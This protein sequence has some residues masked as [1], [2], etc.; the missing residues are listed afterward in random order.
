M[1]TRKSAK[2]D[3]DSFNKLQKKREKARA[4]GET[5][6]SVD[7]GYRT[8]KATPRKTNIDAAKLQAGWDA[9]MEAR[10]SPEFR[11]AGKSMR[12]VEDAKDRASVERDRAREASHYA[13][14]IRDHTN[15]SARSKQDQNV[16][17]AFQRAQLAT[18]KRAALDAYFTARMKRDYEKKQKST[19]ED[20][21]ARAQGDA[22]F[23]DIVRR[24]RFAGESYGTE[25]ERAAAYING[26]ER[27]GL[28]AYQRARYYALTEDEKN[29]VRYF[30][31]KHDWDTVQRYLDAKEQ[32]L[33]ARVMGVYDKKTQEFA[34]KHPFLGAAGHAVNVFTAPA[35]YFANA[36]QMIQNRATG[37]YVP[38]DKNSAAFSG[39]HTRAALGEGIGNTAERS[40][41]EYAY[42]NLKAAAEKAG[43]TEEQMRAAAAKGG[44]I[45]REAANIG[46]SML[47]NAITLPLGEASLAA[48]ALASAGDTTYDAL[49]RGATPGQAFAAGTA[50]GA[51]EAATEKLPLENILKLGKGGTAGFAKNVAKQFGM[52]ALEE[53]ISNVAG[54]IADQVIMGELSNY[55]QLVQQFMQQGASREEAERRANYQLYLI[56][57]LKSALAGG[58]SGGLMA[59]SA[60]V[61]GAA[62]Q[63]M[64]RRAASNAVNDAYRAMAQDGM[65]SDRARQAAN[66]AAAAQQSVLTPQMTVEQF[67][68]ARYETVRR[69]TEQQLDA[70]IEPVRARVQQLESQ[71][72]TDPRDP[73]TAEYTKAKN[74][75]NAYET[76]R[77][78]RL[79][80]IDK[81]YGMAYTEN[82]ESRA[83]WNEE[84]R[85]NW[86]EQYVQSENGHGILRE[87]QER[88][89]GIDGSGSSVSGRSETRGNRSDLGM[90][91]PRIDGRRNTGNSLRNLSEE[92][93]AILNDRNSPNLQ[94]TES[95]SQPEVFS[96][97]LND[98]I[99]N[100]KYGAYVSPHSA[101]ELSQ[102]AAHT[103]LSPDGMAGVAVFRDGNIG[104]V[105]NNDRSNIR[106]ASNDLIL[107]ALSNGGTKLDNFDGRLSSI[108]RRYG[109]IP[110]ARVAFD[111][112]EAPDGWKSEFG[113]PDVIFWMHN[114]DAP[115]TVAGRIGQYGNY[116]TS[117][118]PLFQ[119]YGDAYAYR[120]QLLAN[121]K[122]QNHQASE[123]SGAFSMP[124]SG[125]RGGK[126]MEESVG[127]AVHD[128]NSYSALQ[129]RYGTIK[130]GENPAR[131]VDVPKKT[132]DTHKVRQFAR[133]A[134]EAE[135][136]PDEFI[137]GLEEAVKDG[138][139]S[140]TPK[141]N[142]KSL[143]K[144]AKRI[145]TIGFDAAVGEFRAKVDGNER[146]RAED[147]ALGELILAEAG[148][149]KD[150][151]LARQ[152]Y[153]D[154]AIL[155]TESGQIV[156]IA[157]ALKKLGPSGKYY[158]ISRMVD[159]IKNRVARE[160]K[161][162]LTQE[163]GQETFRVVQ[164]A[165][166]EAKQEAAQDVSENMESLLVER[167]S[168]KV[169]RSLE[170]E[171]T[172]R[173]Q[174]KNGRIPTIRDILTES[175]ARKKELVE[176]IQAYL[177]ESNAFPGS[178][179]TAAAEAIASE[180]NRILQSKSEEI[181]K[182]KLQG[183]KAPNVKEKDALSALEKYLRLGALD[184]E[185]FSDAAIKEITG[186]SGIVVPEELLQNYANAKTD[187][188]TDAALTEIEKSI[189]EQIPADLWD[190][191][192][193]WRYLS[194][195]FNPLT[196]GKNFV[197]NL[198]GMPM[199]SLQNA[200]QV[201]LERRMIPKDSGMRTAA[202]KT[203]KSMRDFAG[204]HLD[205]VES[206]T[207]S[208]YNDS[209]SRINQHRKIFKTKWLEAVR[210][211]NMN[212]LEWEDRV[213]KKHVFKLAFARMAKANGWT[214][215][216]LKSGTPEA[217]A[218][219]D[220]LIGHATEKALES[221]FQEAN[222]LAEA[223]SR[224]KAINR[225]KFNNGTLATKAGQAAKYFALNSAMA[226]AKTPVN[227]SKQS[228]R[229]SGAMLLADIGATVHDVR[230]AGERA[231][232]R[233]EAA[234]LKQAALVKGLDHIAGGLSGTVLVG[235]GAL[236][237]GLDWLRVEGD[238]E[239]KNA[240][241]RMQ[242]EQN[243]SIKLGDQSVSITWMQ[244][245]AAPLLLGAE[246]NKAFEK[247][248]EDFNAWRAV[249][250]LSH[251]IDPITEAS[252]MKGPAD[253]FKTLRNS[254][255]N[256]LSE[257]A[258]T[259]ASGY[260]NQFSPSLL[261]AVAKTLDDTRRTTYSGFA[262]NIEKTIKQNIIRKAVSKTPG[263]S[264]TLEPYVDAWGR[265]DVTQD[266]LWRAAKAFLLPGTPT[267]LKKTPVDT[268][269][270]RLV[271]ATSDDDLYP[272]RAQT[273]VR[274]HDNTYYLMP[275]ELTRYQKTMG[276]TAFNTLNDLFRTEAYKKLSSD[277]QAKV[278][279]DIYDY[280]RDKARDE[281][282]SGRQ[283]IKDE[284]N[285]AVQ[286]VEGA[287]K[288]GIRV[289]DYFMQKNLLRDG[290][291][292]KQTAERLDKLLTA[293][294]RSD[295]K[296]KEVRRK[297]HD[298]YNADRKRRIIMNS[299]FTAE[300]KKYLAKSFDL[301]ETTDYTNE[302]KYYFSQL[303]DS[304]RE[305]WAEASRR[306]GNMTE[307]QYYNII[308]AC[309]GLKKKDEI[310]RVLQQNGFTPR[311]ADNFYK[312][313]FSPQK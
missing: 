214:I 73:L 120:D 55:S 264:K 209:N 93:R 292:S 54:N 243:Y 197:G 117:T 251:V 53:G 126:I 128:P 204:T 229:Y 114:G 300:Q 83:T 164:E 41:A 101:K 165:A 218:A 50:S 271:S 291:D 253:I 68:K 173:K 171:E 286:K 10:E 239:K 88:V 90:E 81:M 273:S 110:V 240:F 274:V 308:D 260:I 212:A 67:N 313:V 246:L 137:P 135:V 42:R 226:F 181:L 277:E 48:M 134:M 158:A 107:T 112:A 233:A 192:D 175:P 216:F 305:R 228:S 102:D 155:F 19:I 98:A 17:I 35:A 14:Y 4:N 2:F 44:N 133:T 3:M 189:A 309:S 43:A 210:K 281:F 75:L 23:S 169:M 312:V 157:S 129:G 16:S 123:E 285:A 282:I 70:L 306:W 269:I 32:I 201:L 311:G 46:L 139:F 60:Q 25:G 160:R 6:Q 153:L 283:E 12:E 52:E 293:A 100:N 63:N 221:T 203:D 247:N 196:H 162:K 257:L 268:E 87:A 79:R 62:R 34:E 206:I 256:E 272:K 267:T 230:K 266:P 111:P 18:K 113:T 241:E 108:Y 30:A 28:D 179:A 270:E 195:L 49:Q 147:I 82:Q 58:I 172:T 94:L 141:S 148:T 69:N 33:N 91:S 279:K 211:F 220:K 130:P 263:L 1:G 245:I 290:D 64:A 289:E 280:A 56:D 106:G 259:L 262:T 13:K 168:Q 104:A 119:S 36:G 255:G 59:T 136:T 22:D 85:A 92:T 142:E 11:F 115:E 304:K 301:G 249:E 150:F 103:Y 78:N 202:L 288:I 163:M 8:P 250:A 307:I 222:A 298:G 184:N 275:E 144:A 47:D 231:K 124:E 149:Q 121:Q 236:L 186:H 258:Q 132:D 295:F 284:P 86:R 96:S 219:M 302:R 299:D 176:K 215:D 159:R 97:R 89:P 248:G 294:Q 140:Y 182:Q 177:L 178:D 166:Q 76:I 238:D 190:K 80:E 40:A 310:V 152:T 26:D 167:L 7:S 265:E 84:N 180:F 199:R 72:S 235:I 65:F 38:T 74:M 237:A 296:K 45:G 227:I 71:M 187:A 27:P 131:V 151:E 232:T 109:F 224:T 252:F 20:I 143:R 125:E 276:Q 118:L 234:N 198:T 37:D 254:K 105:F 39:V 303:S 205:A 217:N 170:S 174:K 185:A 29:I 21:V 154:L 225:E 193:G 207:S 24:G 57:T 122:T 213:C 5:I 287:K 145:R 66:T 146:I 261:G 95:T 51:I 242:G 297:D 191:L 156:Q 194:M 127:A 278:V 138:A 223:I 200:I 99:T 15:Q 183:E 188:E 161:A 31:A 77:D 244:P 61:V 208:K 116:D 9:E